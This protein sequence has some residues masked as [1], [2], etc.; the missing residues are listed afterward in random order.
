[1][2][3]IVFSQTGP[4]SFKFLSVFIEGIDLEDILEVDL[5]IGGR[6]GGGATHL[7]GDSSKND[8]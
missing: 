1:M 2:V 4:T 8:Q 6:G 7:C 5:L 3:A